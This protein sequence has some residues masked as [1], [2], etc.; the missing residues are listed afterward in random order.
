MVKPRKDVHP[1]PQSKG[2]R[3]AKTSAVFRLRAHVLR[4]LSGLLSVRHCIRG[5][6]PRAASPGWTARFLVRR[7]G[8][9]RLRVADGLRRA[10]QHHGAPVVQRALDANCSMG[11]RA[12]DVRALR[13]PGARSVVLAMAAPWNSGVVGAERGRPRR[14]MDIVCRRLDDRPGDDTL[15]QPFRSFWPASGMAPT[16]GQTLHPDYVPNSAAVSRRSASAIPRIPSC[17]LDDAEHD[18][19]TLAVCG[20]NNRLHRFGDPVRGERSD[21]RTRRRVHGVSP[22]GSHAA[23][24]WKLRGREDSDRGSGNRRSGGSPE[25]ALVRS[26]SSQRLL[27]KYCHFLSTGA[28]SRGILVACTIANALA[29]G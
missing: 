1:Y 20:G 17:V 22:K 11:N 2:G 9:H 23:A 18:T 13:E 28:K 27:V 4:D 24:H 29:E 26:H 21:P 19:R 8:G 3:D 5:R 6:V 12:I 10:A 14:L 15:H 7:G 25:G 16:H